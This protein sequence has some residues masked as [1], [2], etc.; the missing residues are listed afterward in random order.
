MNVRAIAIGPLLLIAAVVLGA[1]V[2]LA[3]RRKG[4]SWVAAAILAVVGVVAVLACLV[5]F[6]RARRFV[7]V[8]GPITQVGR[9]TD[10]TA[11]DVGAGAWSAQ[12]GRA[13]LAD[14]YPSVPAAAEALAADVAAKLAS[15]P[16]AG[17][18]LPLVMVT[19]NAGSEALQRFFRQPARVFRW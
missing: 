13:F 18:G 5:F 16:A 8:R 10:T 4:G 9:L 14:V 6:L 17:A 19:G 11:Q 12:A 15:S 3:L 1:V 2:L 7:H